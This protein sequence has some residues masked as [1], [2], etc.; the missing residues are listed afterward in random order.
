MSLSTHSKEFF[1]LGSKPARVLKASTAATYKVIYRRCMRKSVSKREPLFKDQYPNPAAV[2][3]TDMVEDWLA[4]TSA[5]KKNYVN[6]ERSALLW[7]LTD[8]RPPDWLSAYTRLKTATKERAIRECATVA[9]SREPGRMIPPEDL[10]MLLV[11]LANM[12]KP[13]AQA[14]TW[15]LAGI[16]SGIRPVEWPYSRWIDEKKTIVRVY[17]SRAE[18]HRAWHQIPPMTFTTPDLDNEVAKLWGGRKLD[19]SGMNWA[20]YEVDFERRV[21]SLRLSEDDRAT[22]RA[23]QTKNG[24]RLFRDVFIDEQYRHEVQIHLETLQRVIT[25]TRAENGELGL[26]LS[27]D[28]LFNHYYFT[29]LRHTIWRACKKIFV[30]RTYSLADTRQ[31]WLAKQTLKVVPLKFA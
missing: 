25:E 23:A 22:L 20:H 10:S 26:N 18:A 1:L 27:D 15:L 30:N 3:A 13:G 2:T 21:A 7:V 9:H 29:P 8:Q 16:G 17:A 19:K 14:K 12:R 28:D 5:S 24:M 31:N 4:A 6:T 11:E